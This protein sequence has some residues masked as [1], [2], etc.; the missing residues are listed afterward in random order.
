MTGDIRDLEPF[1]A[2]LHRPVEDVTGDLRAF[3]TLLLKW[4]RAKNLVSRE[5]SQDD[6]WHRHVLDSVQLLVYLP[7]AAAIIVD[8]GSGGGFPA[9][10]MAIALKGGRS[11]FH[12][13]ESNARKAAFL[14]TAA[15][16]L[17]LPATVHAMRID[18]FAGRVKADV[19]S[20]RALAPLPKLLELIEPLWH[21]DCIA[22]LPKGREVLEEIADCRET[23][24]FSMLKH[25]SR[26][27]DSGVVLELHELARK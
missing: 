4:Q 8:V 22:L 25:P 20:A 27:D 23:W 5:T 12:L 17:A 18:D 15:R 1:T 2:Y 24:S 3:V 19:I 9:L 7:P 26:S 10:P 14:R 11:H 13:V 6:I 21:P 16:E